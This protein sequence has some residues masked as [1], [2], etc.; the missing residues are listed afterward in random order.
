GNPNAKG[1]AVNGGSGNP[2]RK[3]NRKATQYTG[4]KPKKQELFRKTSSSKLRLSARSP[5]ARA[6]RARRNGRLSE[7]RRRTSLRPA[8]RLHLPDY[9]QE[10]DHCDQFHPGGQHE[11]PKELP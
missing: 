11:G 7:T 5:V 1:E 2:E 4:K 9:E 8:H 6:P 3:S 10:H